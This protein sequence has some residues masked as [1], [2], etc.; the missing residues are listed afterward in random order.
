MSKKS[1]ARNAAASSGAPASGNGA[2]SLAA[3][4]NAG[5]NP[6][7]PCPCGSGRRYKACHGTGEDVIV[8][9]PFAGLAC[10]CDLVALR[11]FV[12]SAVTALPLSAAGRA[13]AGDRKPQLASVLPGA[14]AAAVRPDGAVLVGMQV[15]TR[16]G[17]IS[18]DLARA[19]RWA[20]AAEPG[21]SLPV[22]GASLGGGP[23]RLQDLLEPDGALELALHHDFAWWFPDGQHTP[24]V[25]AAIEHANSVIKPTEQVVADRV[26]AA[27]WV[28]AGDKAHLRWVRPEPEERLLAALA[29]LQ[30]GGRLDLGEGS[31]YVGS[32]RAH[33]L[34]VPV[35]DLDR[36]MHVKE[37][38]EPT[39][40]FAVALE[41][42]LASLDAEPLTDTERRSRDALAGRQVTLR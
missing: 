5:P 15:Q 39:A 26:R 6:R 10:E 37:W 36:E 20:L 2:S 17:D 9:R 21:E 30:A 19:L 11:E 22:S 32:F 28:D 38:S 3:S 24:E 25:K 13:L 16:T 23:V 40:A 8:L 42:T 7:Q 41:Q 34:L 1:R 18:G 27:Y 4:A 14:A 29:R 31:R 35:W 33:G 12:P